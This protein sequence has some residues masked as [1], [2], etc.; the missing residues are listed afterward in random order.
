MNSMATNYR[1]ATL[2]LYLPIN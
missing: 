2:R 1:I